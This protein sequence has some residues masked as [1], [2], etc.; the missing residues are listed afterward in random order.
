[1]KFTFLGTCAGTEPLPGA[2]HTSFSVES[3]KSL[4]FFDAGENCS[5]T[6]HLSGVDL[7]KLRAVFISHTHMD[8]VGGLAN[9]FWTVRK[10]ENVK[11]TRNAFDPITLKI[12][13]LETF[14]GIW[15]LLRNSEGNFSNSF[16]IS[17]S[18]TEEGCCYQ[19]DTIQ[20][21]AVPNR[22][23]VPLPD[24][25]PI[26]YSYRFTAEGKNIVFSG[27]VKDMTDLIPLFDQPI[28]L[29]LVETG[30][31]T[32]EKVCGQLAE[33]SMHP[34]MLYFLHNGRPLLDDMEGSEKN[35]RRLFGESAHILRDAETL[36]L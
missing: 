33:N 26:S 6:A 21:I 23:L 12:P 29:L 11:K 22:H 28:D 32:V 19:D 7:L 10:L 5:Y 34:K 13:I 24:G 4:Y 3:G 35:A 1:M 14:E 31:H 36:E 17:A 18:R 8:H 30:H 9:L 20:V 25:T 15:K 27:D 2:H 16:S